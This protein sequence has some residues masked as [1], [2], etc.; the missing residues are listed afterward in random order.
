MNI[1]TEDVLHP[2]DDNL[3]YI[4]NVHVY[5]LPQRETPNTFELWYG[6]ANTPLGIG[7]L[8]R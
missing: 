3:K 8:E 5:V 7:I 6:F 2:T 4:V 1:H